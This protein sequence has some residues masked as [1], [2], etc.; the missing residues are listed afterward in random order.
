MSSS[1]CY[2]RRPGKTW[3]PAPV[4]Y[5]RIL[6]LYEELQSNRRSRQSDPVTIC[7]SRPDGEIMIAQVSVKPHMRGVFACEV[8]EGADGPFELMR[9][10]IALGVGN[11]EEGGK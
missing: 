8:V 5:Q 2:F 3:E 7:T 10:S 1:I 4:V 6:D 9:C 11:K